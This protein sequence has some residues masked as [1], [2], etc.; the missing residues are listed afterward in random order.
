MSAL[1]KR[2]R[3]VVDE[4]KVE[5]WIAE[6]FSLPDSSWQQLTVD[7]LSMTV[8]HRTL[9]L[10]ASDEN[11][12]LFE[13]VFKETRETVFVT[14]RSLKCVNGECVF[15]GTY[16]EREYYQDS[17]GEWTRVYTVTVA[18]DGATSLAVEYA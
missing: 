17:Y 4:L 12:E 10:Q 2:F 14:P 16:T 3:D 1:E 5:E 13:R 11:D 18:R 6:G 7:G 15:V 9:R 8:V